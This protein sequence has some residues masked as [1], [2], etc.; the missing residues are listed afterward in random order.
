MATS[1]PS[2]SFFNSRR[3]RAIL[4]TLIAYAF[5]FPA[6]LVLFVFHIFPVGFAVFVSLHR[7]RRFP[8]EYRGLQNYQRA[9][10]DFAFV[11]F[12]WIALALLIY[13][14]VMLYRLWRDS[15]EAPSER[16]YL[17]PGI[18][19]A[20]AVLLFV[21]WFFLLLPV[22]LDIPVRLRGQE[23]TRDL[24]VGEFFNSF[25]FPE[26]FEAGNQML[27]AIIL[28][29]GMSIVFYRLI[30][31]KQWGIR[32]LHATIIFSLIAASFLVMQLTVTEMEAAVEE[33][34]D[35]SALELEHATEALTAAESA[36]PID[37]EK[38]ER[39]QLRLA[40]AELAQGQLPLTVKVTLITVGVFLIVVAFFVW[41]RGTRQQDNRNFV[42]VASA[43]IALILGGYILIAELPQVIANADDDLWNGFRNTVFFS[44][45][46]VP[47]QLAVGMVL[48]Y[49]LFQ[50]IRGRGLFRLVYFLPYV[51]PFV[52]T[53]A[54][55]RIIFSNE[56]GS[57]ANQ[58][59]GIFGVAPQTWLLEP[60]GITQLLIPDTINT[61]QSSN[62]IL[63]EW[64]AG[65]SLAL[66][67]IIFY[68]MWTYIGYSAVIFLAGLGNIPGELYEAARIDGASRWH[69]FRNITFPLLSPT[70][71][72]LSIIAVI[73]T[74]KAF[75]QIF[76]MRSPSASSA[77]ETAS[78]YIFDTLRNDTRYGYGSAMAFVLFAIILALTIFQN[79]YLGR[80]VFYG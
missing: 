11:V 25:Q 38:L 45:T 36:D 35:D 67:A 43:A 32:L 37:N 64:L 59:L 4:E 40:E 52:A 73:G 23:V 6:G 41:R 24:F 71:F 74:F 54:V 27:L 42:L 60:K 13:A 1:Q 3:G 50:D 21:R 78:I 51:M 61:I 12:T 20:A 72:F 30:Q 77:V 9:L 75:V 19:N 62:P 46:A 34:R 48:A 55:F 56:P 53:S 58:F 22:V 17:I 47:I 8:E 29:V 65:P 28:A 44:F 2:T 5:L 39:A 31:S 16:A 14:L 79:R 63:G 15:R 76:I 57:P 33:Y 68:S 26:V 80:R 10:G 70:T 18:F 66:L 69:E 49:F 7:W